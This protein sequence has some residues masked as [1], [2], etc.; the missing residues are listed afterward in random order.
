MNIDRRTCTMA[1]LPLM[2]VGCTQGMM[3]GGKPVVEFGEYNR[4][5]MASQVVNPEPHYDTTVPVTSAEHAAQAA[6]RYQ[7][8]AVKP[9]IHTPSTTPSSGN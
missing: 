4:Q 8:D 2:L 7:Q 5:T 1:A 9:P 3:T 6:E